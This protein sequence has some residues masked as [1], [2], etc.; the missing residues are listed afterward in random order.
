MPKAKD[1]QNFLGPSHCFAAANHHGSRPPLVP[2]QP[3]PYQPM[4][5]DNGSIWIGYASADQRHRAYKDFP[6]FADVITLCDN[7]M[8]AGSSTETFPKPVLYPTKKDI[9]DGCR[10]GYCGACVQLC[11][12]GHRCDSLKVWYQREILK[13]S[14]G[15]GKPVYFLLYKFWMGGELMAALMLH[16]GNN[17]WRFQQMDG[18]L[19]RNY[20]LTS[21]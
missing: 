4:P 21:K 8:K 14:R 2:S 13:E 7:N 1:G 20:S 18:K 11:Y 6:S 17:V 15:M 16:K 12:K 3:E 9:E 10:T 19:A 5:L